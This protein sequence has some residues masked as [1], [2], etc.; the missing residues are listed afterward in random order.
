MSPLLYQNKLGN[1]AQVAIKETVDILEEETIQKV[2]ECL[3]SAELFLYGVGASSL[4]VEDILQKWS[5]VGKPIIFEKDIH[6]LLP[7]L[8]S[9]EKKKVLWLV[10]NSGRSADV[11]ALAELAKSMNIEI[12]ALTQFGNNPLSKIADVL[13]Q[14]SRPKEITNRSA[15]TNSLLAQFATIDIIL[16]LYG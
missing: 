10:S 2:V 9:N 15:A 16:F 5:R 13:V 3:E 14:T 4:V 7:Q 12:I 6:V 11:V 1:N 8:V